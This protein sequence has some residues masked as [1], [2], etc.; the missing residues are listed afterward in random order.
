RL[1]LRAAGGRGGRLPRGGLRGGRRRSS[2][3]GKHR[4]PR[5]NCRGKR[6]RRSFS[7]CRPSE[8]GSRLSKI[9]YRTSRTR[10]CKLRAMKT[11]LA[12]AALFLLLPAP[13]SAQTA[14]SQ[15]EFEMM[16]W[17]EV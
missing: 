15:V 16:T 14:T 1:R 7:H 2:T 13:A 3:L 9:G 4:D 17:P 11:F 12:L 5:E 6:Q 10:H 8:I